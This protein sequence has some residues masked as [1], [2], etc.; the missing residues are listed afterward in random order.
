MCKIDRG[1]DDQK[2]LWR[3]IHKANAQSSMD[4]IFNKS[5]SNDPKTLADQFADTFYS[6]YINDCVPNNFIPRNVAAINNSLNHLTVNKNDVGE[7]LR[8]ERLNSSPRPDNIHPR[9]FHECASEIAPSQTALFNL[10]LTSGF[11]PDD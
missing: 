8:S 7:L 9:V 5:H 4:E 2:K 1:H 10:S 11:L 6:N 3:H